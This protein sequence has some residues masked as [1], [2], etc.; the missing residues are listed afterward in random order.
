M[1]TD[2]FW[3]FVLVMATILG[4]FGGFPAPPK[5]FK[6][7]TSFQLVQWGLVA[8]LAY[9]GGGGENIML[10][11]IMTALAF[12][13]YMAFKMFESK[14]YIVL[15]DV[16]LGCSGAAAV[17]AAKKVAAVATEVVKKATASS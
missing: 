15:D 6:W 9:Q 8:V 13:V 2:T 16:D 5:F 11:L 1:L 4:A 17:D 3:R 10:S 14:D 12:V 7:V